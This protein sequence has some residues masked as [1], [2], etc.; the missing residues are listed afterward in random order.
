MNAYNAAELIV[1]EPLL[2]LAWFAFA[3]AATAGLL[4]RRRDGQA[5]AAVL[6]ALALLFP[7]ISVT[8]DFGG[9]KSLEEIVAILTA[10]AA[11]VVLTAL[12]RLPASTSVVAP[13]RRTV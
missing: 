7:I 10:I 6:C 8:D 13:V 12:F 11:G 9:G 5:V 1:T 4:V 2:N 3:L